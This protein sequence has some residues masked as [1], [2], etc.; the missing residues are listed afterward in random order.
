MIQIFNTHILKCRLNLNFYCVLEVKIF[1]N[2]C[3]ISCTKIFI[4]VLFKSSI[5]CILWSLTTVNVANS[6]KWQ[7]CHS[8]QIVLFDLNVTL[9]FKCYAF[10]SV[11]MGSALPFTHTFGG[12]SLFLWQNFSSM[13][14]KSVFAVGGHFWKTVYHTE[15]FMRNTGCVFQQLLLT[16]NHSGIPYYTYP[17]V[18]ELQKFS[19]SSCLC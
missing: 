9:A 4:L 15:V 11:L 6:P 10:P 2:K 3:L 13:T 7:T 16:L 8:Y 18:T 5:P 19:F 12:T 1:Q 14:Y 17:I